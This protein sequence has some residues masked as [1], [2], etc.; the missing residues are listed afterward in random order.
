MAA[1]LIRPPGLG[2]SLLLDGTVVEVTGESAAYA[3][4]LPG[5][6]ILSTGT[7]YDESYID[8]A[9][10][11]DGENRLI[12]LWLG[13]AGRDFGTQAPQAWLA[14]EA[15]RLGLDT[16]NLVR[17]MIRQ[18]RGLRVVPDEAD[19]YAT[20]ADYRQSLAVDERLHP[21][22]D[23]GGAELSDNIAE[24]GLDEVLAAPPS[25]TNSLQP[26][27]SPWQGPPRQRYQSQ[28]PPARYMP[29]PIASAGG[30]KASGGAFAAFSLTRFVG[31]SDNATR[32][33]VQFDGRGNV[34]REANKH[35]GFSPGR[36][37]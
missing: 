9:V 33:Y 6:V 5:V 34:M 14:S 25:L 32:G 36:R 30:P 37:G 2:F 13:A 22:L 4:L 1:E 12:H 24:P 10:R 15:D 17:M 35:F 19:S 21:D 18:R 28:R 26:R 31:L 7:M 23:D 11:Q 27:S 8:V 20:V 16:E 3:D 29:V